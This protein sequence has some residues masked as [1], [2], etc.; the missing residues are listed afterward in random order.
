MT[1]VT[2]LFPKDDN[3]TSTNIYFEDKL[4][5]KPFNGKAFNT[6]PDGSIMWEGEIKNG[7][8]NGIEIHYFRNGK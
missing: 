2:D 8:L 3:A 6:Y 7:K 4:L 5:T 1:T